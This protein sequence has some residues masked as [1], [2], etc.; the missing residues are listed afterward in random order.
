MADEAYRRLE[1]VAYCNQQYG[2]QI[3]A[4]I[5]DT[6]GGIICPHCDLEMSIVYWPPGSEAVIVAFTCD[7][8]GRGHWLGAWD[9]ADEHPI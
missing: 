5:E 4:R 9:A 1:V 8:S 3:R 6:N 2:E 7:P